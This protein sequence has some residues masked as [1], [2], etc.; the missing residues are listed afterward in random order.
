MKK[1]TKLYDSLEEH[2]AC[3]VGFVARLDARPD[4]SLVEDAV[5]ALARMAH[6]GGA[7]HDPNQADG[8]GLL[9]PIPRLFMQ[10]VWGALCGEI[11]ER[12]G[13]G[14][15]FLPRDVKMRERAEEM[16]ES[17]LRAQ[18]L[19]PLAWRDTPLRTEVLSATAL[20]SLPV[21][22]QLLV[23]ATG[24]AEGDLER[25]LFMAR[26]HMETMAAKAMA[27]PRRD[28]HVAS[29]SCR[30]VIYKGMLPGAHLAAL[31]PDLADRDFAVH[32]VIFHERYST[33][34][35]PAWRLAQPFRCLAHNG[36]INT[37]RSNQMA[38]HVREPI[39]AS[40]LFGNHLQNMLP[41][42][43]D[44]GSDSAMLDN[45]MEM[46]LHSGR[47]LAH[48]AMMLIP[49]PF[50]KSFIMGEDKRAFYEYHAA[51]MEPWDG[52]AA[53]VFTDG[54][55][56]IGAVL[57]RNALRPSRYCVT[58][59][60]KFLLASEAGVLDI[61]PSRVAKRG[62]LQP[63]KM[64]LVDFARHRVV[65]DAECKG[66]V[67]YGK[68]YRH[69]IR[70]YG[71]GLSD[72]PLPAEPE[73][74]DKAPLNAAKRLHGYTLEDITDI[75][76]P[77]AANA[78][79]PVASMGDD[80]PLAVLSQKPQLLFRFFKQRFAQV[81]NPPIDPLRE[82]L[83][84]S[85]KGFVGKQ[86]NLLEETPDHY[87]KLRL[88]HPILPAKDLARI[89]ASSHPRINTAE[90]PMLFAKP[91]E[92]AQKTAL[93]VHTEGNALK[94]GL[95]ALFKAAET[96]LDAGATVLLLSDREADEAMLPIPSLL[97]VSALH[98]HLVRVRRRHACGIV[99][100]AGDAREVMHAAQLI[101]FG[102]NAVHPRVALR[103]VA[104]MAENGELTGAP[105]D[106]RVR[107]AEDAYVTAL[108]KGLL[109]TFARMG[110]S[111]VRSFCGGQGF[112]ALGLSADV[113]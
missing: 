98:Q 68:P 54:S 2:D 3:G 46:L 17:A 77:M 63:R 32:F 92:D 90:L 81:T 34:T 42:L 101:A 25:R 99:V 96:A 69:W 89:R 24:S 27:F 84:M 102:A 62:R 64:L 36:E 8:A 94:A 21:I 1:S 50:G 43:D 11:P 35:T 66:R 86:S 40:P 88:P 28:F 16:A 22:R 113:I 107:S 56:R 15:F 6:R 110:I 55:R 61:P 57:D 26:R 10:R 91:Q 108:K 30:S 48:A 53:L 31:Y 59:D 18:G 47:S 78:Q 58:K 97:A 9:M 44:T 39:L 83:V 72:L 74:A 100:D 103:I 45:A 93:S 60:G 38:L 41:V 70:E 71:I 14:H 111:T 49:E 82:E 12:Y 52:P 73:R 5:S 109:K 65:T 104:A 79:E 105:G 37:I 20:E 29:L 33:N 4:H 87:A 75:I 85:L 112:E 67:I 13:V 80:T 106:A 19:H 95:D 7:G 51:M 76:K 23:D